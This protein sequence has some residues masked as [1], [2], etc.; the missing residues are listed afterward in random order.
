ML[1]MIVDIFNSRTQV[2]TLWALLGTVAAIRM[3]AMHE[4]DEALYSSSE[5]DSEEVSVA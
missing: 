4:A 3:I 5:D 2:Q 1:H